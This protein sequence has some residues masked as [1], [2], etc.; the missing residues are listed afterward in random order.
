MLRPKRARSVGITHAPPVRFP[1]QVKDLAPGCADL[2]EWPDPTTKVEA[3]NIR[4]P[5][6]TWKRRPTSSLRFS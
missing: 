3:A 5:G 1:V 6:K 2:Y 4:L